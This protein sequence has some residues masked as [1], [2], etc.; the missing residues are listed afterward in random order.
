[1]NSPA[2]SAAWGRVL[3]WVLLSLSAVPSYAG[4]RQLLESDLVTPSKKFSADLQQRTNSSGPV[5]VIVQYRQ[6]PANTHFQT[7][8]AGGATIKS[9]H[10]TIGAVAM[11]VPASMMSQMAKDDNIVHISPDRP[12]HSTNNGNPTAVLDYH[13]ETVNAPQ[14]WAQG[15]DGTGVGVAIIDSGRHD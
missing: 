15:L 9:M 14:A 6:M 5:D 12:L 13:V 1:M 11:R 3:A 2:F 7:L 10:P 8:R 4:T